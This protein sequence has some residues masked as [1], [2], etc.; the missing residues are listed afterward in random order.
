M[1]VRPPRLSACSKSSR[2][3]KR[4]RCTHLSFSIVR[5]RATTPS[6]RGKALA[7]GGGGAR[8]RGCARRIAMP[9]LIE[10]ANIEQIISN[11]L[12]MGRAADGSVA[13]LNGTPGIG[14]T[15]M[16]G[17]AIQRAQEEGFVVAEAVASRMER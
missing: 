13:F 2:H 3:A 8:A 6:I 4:A 17:W 14:K 11:T 15:A 1:S 7:R 9:D 5:P 12:V 10:R 16:L